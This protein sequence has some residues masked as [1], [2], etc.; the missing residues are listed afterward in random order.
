[1]NEDL[2]PLFDKVISTTEE[3]FDWI[4]E[5]VA[6]STDTF[7]EFLAVP[8]TIISMVCAI[9]VIVKKSVIKSNSKFFMPYFLF[10]NTNLFR[11]IRCVMA[12]DANQEKYAVNPKNMYDG[13]NS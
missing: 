6:D 4:K 13:L 8:E 10:Y 1:M 12:N 7:F 5:I 9:L 2:P 11:S 3:S